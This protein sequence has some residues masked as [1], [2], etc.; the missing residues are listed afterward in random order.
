VT[1]PK[2]P[3][4]RPKKQAA[5]QEG[6]EAGKNFGKAMLRIVGMPKGRLDEIRSEVKEKRSK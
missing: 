3:G 6:E 2:H 1:K 5:Y 4:G